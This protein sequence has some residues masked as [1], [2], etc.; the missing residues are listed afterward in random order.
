MAR[1]TERELDLIQ[2]NSRP[3]GRAW[4]DPMDLL[5]VARRFRASYLARVTG[6]TDLHEGLSARI[7]RPI[8]QAM[9]RRRT[10]RELSRLDDRMLRDIGLERDQ[11]EDYAAKFSASDMTPT[12]RPNGLFA[13]IRSWNERRVAIKELEGLDDR[14]LRDIGLTRGDIQDAVTC[15]FANVAPASV[16]AETGAP[17]PVQPRRSLLGGL[18]AR[19]L[20][21]LRHR[22]RVFRTINELRALDDR[23]LAD[24]GLSRGQIPMIASNLAAPL[25]PASKA[26]ATI[27]PSPLGSVVLT[28]RRWNLSRLAASQMA[29]LGPDTLSD[30]GY[31]KGDIDWV[32]EVLANRTLQTG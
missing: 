1:L 4:N 12:A 5:L 24:I 18:A 23:M 19:A 30:L 7:V 22:H 32:P 17:T 16:L 2:R 3:L 13:L 6:L 25:E 28:M 10:I 26:R 20:S 9:E 11:I 29:R 27:Q 15:G 21:A 14:L 8:R 31:V